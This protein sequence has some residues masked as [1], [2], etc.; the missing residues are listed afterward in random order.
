MAPSPAN[1]ADLLY[2][3]II[4]PFFLKHESQ[5]D[6]VVN[7]LKDKAKETADTIS[8]EGMAW[9][10]PGSVCE[11]PGSYWPR[12]RASSLHVLLAFLSHVPRLF[13]DFSTKA[14][15][16]AFTVPNILLPC[17]E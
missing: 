8:K 5:V 1:G 9:G 12:Q 11:G 7:D 10:Q 16:V 13:W 2:K 15:P 4:R 6:T 3:R 14:L 17:H